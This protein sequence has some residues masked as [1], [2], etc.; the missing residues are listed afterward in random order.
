MVEILFDQQLFSAARRAL[1]NYPESAITKLKLSIKSQLTAEGSF[2][3]LNKEPDVYMSSFGFSL[4]TLLKVD[5]KSEESSRYLKS[6]G[7]GENLSFLH[8]TS[9]ARSW[10]FF[11]NDSLNADFYEKIAEKIEFNRTKDRAWNQASGTHYGSVY[12]TYL[13]ISAYHNLDLSAPDE[14]KALPA[15]KNLKSKDGVFG[16]DRGADSGSTPATAMAVILLTYLP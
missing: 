12:G 6:L 10:K 4:Q 1:R 5:L 16:I 9:L 2:L 13:A 3:G 15:L 14:L 8:I 11:S 7:H